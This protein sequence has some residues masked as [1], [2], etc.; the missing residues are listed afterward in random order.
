MFTVTQ[1]KEFAQSAVISVKGY[2]EDH[3]LDVVEELLDVNTPAEPTAA[4]QFLVEELKTVT[5]AVRVSW[6]RGT[7]STNPDNARGPSFREYKEFMQPKLQRAF[8][9]VKI[10]IR[11]S[12]IRPVMAR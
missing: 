11:R 3:V 2:D 5:P 1:V 10:S 7:S 9:D 8:P 12:L 4:R 6:P